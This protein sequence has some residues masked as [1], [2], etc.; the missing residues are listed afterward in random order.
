MKISYNWLKKY[1]T[2]DLSVS[3]TSEILTDIGLEVE[4]IEKFEPIKGE[5]KGVVV[6]KVTSCV[7][8]PDA[9]KLHV[10][11]VNIGEAEPLQIVCGAPNIA[12]NQTVLVATIGTKLFFKTGNE[13]EIKKTKIRGLSS[14]GM[15]CAEDELGIGQ[16]HAGI[17]VLPD[18]FEVGKK[19]S[20]IFDTE[21]D[22]IFEIGLTPNRSD[23]MS[24]YGV[25]RDISAALN[26]RLNK[27]MHALL[28]MIKN[29]KP[30]INENPISIE[31]KDIENC[32]RYS[33]IY[34]ENISV[35]KSPDW[36]KKSLKSVGINSINNI[37]DV[38]NFIMLET[39]QPLHAF[40]AKKIK[41]NKIIV[42]KA[43]PKLFVTLDDVERKLNGSE[44][45]ICDAQNE[46]CIAGIYGGID[47]GVSEN[48]TSI[49]IESA[50]FNSVSIRK[51]S[52]LHGLK[53]DSSFRYER[54][55][56]PEITL[57]A[58]KRVT[59]LLS[60]Q[61]N[62]I[63]Y[64]IISDIYPNPIKRRKINLDIK[65]LWS[66]IG[67]EIPFET[68]KTILISLDFEILAENDNSFEMLAPLYRTDVT[69]EADVIEEVL[70]IYG[71]NSI[72]IPE[73]LSYTPNYNSET[74]E[75]KKN[76]KENISNWLSSIGFYESINNSLSKSEYLEKFDFS[77]KTDAV[78][79]LNPL[80]K[81]L[82]IMRLSLLPGLLENVL[83]NQNYQQTDVK[84]Y[85]FGKHYSY[86]HLFT[87]YDVT[88]KYQEKEFL[89]MI[90]CGNDNPENWKYP[91]VKSDF[92]SIKRIVEDL[93]NFTHTK[94]KLKTSPINSKLIKEGI[95]Y[96]WSDEQPIIKCGTIHPKILKQFDIKQEVFFVEIDWKLFSDL[97]I[98]QTVQFNEINNFQPV[99]RD[100]ALL[101]DKKIEFAEISS[102]AKQSVGKLLKDVKLFDIYEGDKIPSGK[103]SYAIRFTFQ[104]NERTMTEIEINK[105][106]DKLIKSLNTA[107]N[108]EIR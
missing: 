89:S 20:E 59:N 56:D 73:K 36:I 9:D 13:L 38:T 58:L 51:S 57:Y 41:G 14:E 70:R 77:N 35:L 40:D 3:E 6:G 42:R 39:G 79:I 30:S 5:L 86:N 63:K 100:L 11:K 17:M 81:E 106:M 4:S 16:S 68:I 45:M 76:L 67:K 108:F 33:G 82:E 29:F 99:K 47:S 28:P 103:K 24:H 65:N 7:K 88:R 44:L 46:L 21:S 78:K 72:E 26:C 52:K 15:I 18:H 32:L 94:N 49:F 87:E 1:I 34:I 74:N 90:I 19:A 102:I 23:A 69:R 48:T 53:T 92:F 61:F 12:L 85:E 104:N 96:C 50:Y 98:K 95:Q 55:G 80:S 31:I 83:L 75:L 97:A 8:H 93:L 64:S 66:L 101:I 107:I 84:L 25:A 91:I 10:A 62:N 37:V 105:V 27:K 43:N 54:G 22:Y 2:F 71:F 60:E